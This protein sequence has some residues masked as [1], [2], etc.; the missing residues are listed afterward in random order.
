MAKEFFADPELKRL[1]ASRRSAMNR[2]NL[3]RGLVHSNAAFDV[4]H[5]EARNSEVIRPIAQANLSFSRL[6][7]EDATMQLVSGQPSFDCYA[8]QLMPP[9]WR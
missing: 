7:S 6:I 1:C 2:Q 8:D 4:H 5:S 9:S 3:H